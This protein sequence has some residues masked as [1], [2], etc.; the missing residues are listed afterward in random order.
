MNEYQKMR[1]RQQ[2]EFIALPLGFAFKQKQFDK[3]MQ[4]W[5]LHLERDIEKI[6][7]IGNGGYIQK[8]DVALLRQTSAQHSQELA[9]AI[10]ADTTG[11]G[12]IFQMFYYEL[13][14]HEYGYTGEA[15]EALDALGYTL[16]QVQVNQRLRRGFERAC[17]KIMKEEGL[18]FER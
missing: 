15:E 14:N 9:A 1:N 17:K 13:V 4:G 5:G 12:F 2:M 10:E 8:K 7:S 16:E 6:C 11:N 18:S 3:M